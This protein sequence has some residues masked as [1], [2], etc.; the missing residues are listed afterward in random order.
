MLPVRFLFGVSPISPY[1]YII[2]II[3][4]ASSYYNAYLS[5]FIFALSVWSIII[6]SV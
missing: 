5:F 6:A 1:I 4:A 2:N 3:M